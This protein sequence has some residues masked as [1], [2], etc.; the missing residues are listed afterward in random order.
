[1]IR[2]I[3][4]FAIG[5]ALIGSLTPSTFG[6][7]DQRQIAN[8]VQAQPVQVGGVQVQPVQIHPIQVQPVQVQPVQPA[9]PAASATTVHEKSLRSTLAAYVAAYN[10]KDAAKLVE[11]FTPDGTLI[12]SE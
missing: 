9:A 3:E 10:Q 6:Q 12:D 11:L 1:M 8:P 5:V 2:C 4:H 7:I